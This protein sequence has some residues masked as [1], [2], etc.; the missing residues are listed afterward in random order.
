MQIQRYI[1]LQLYCNWCPCQ[2]I[3][4][5]TAQWK[6]FPLT[7]CLNANILKFSHPTPIRC[8]TTNALKNSM[9]TNGN[10]KSP[11]QPYAIMDLNTHPKWQ[12]NWFSLFFAWLIPH[13][14]TLYSAAP[15]PPKK[16]PLHVGGI[17]TASY[18]SFLGPIQ[19]ITP[20][21][22]KSQSAVFPQFTV[23][24]NGRHNEDGTWTTGHLY[25]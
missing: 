6:T 4:F 9:W 25:I 8:Y 3:H 23:A 20:N 1:I 15:F 24:I 16:M 17:W 11:K 18:I 10:Q 13:S 19:P 22:I 7:Y 5:N 14:P 2:K 21:S 12:L